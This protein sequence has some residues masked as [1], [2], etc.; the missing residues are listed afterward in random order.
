LIAGLL[1]PL[2]TK[3]SPPSIAV[4]DV[5][6]NTNILRPEQAIYLHNNL[7]D[8]IDRQRKNKETKVIISTAPTSAGK[9]FV[10]SNVT[11]A[12]LA[13]KN[14]DTRL[15]VVTSP[16]SGCVD[17]LHHG[18]YQT[19]HDKRLKTCNGSYV[20]FRVVNLA[21]FNKG[22]PFDSVEPVVVVLCIHVCKFNSLWTDYGDASIQIKSLVPPD[23]VIVDEIHYGMGTTSWETILADQGRNNKNF[24]PHWL[25]VLLELAKANFGNKP[26]C[27]VIGYTGT[28]TKSQSGATY[29]GRLVFDNSM[30]PMLKKK[31]NSTFVQGWKS[32]TLKH[33]YAHSKAWIKAELARLQNIINNIDQ[34]TWDEAETIGIT[35]IIPGGL[36]KFGRKDST[37]SIRFEEGFLDG[38]K[39]D[40]KQWVLSIGADYAAVTST[41]TKKEYAS[42]I[43][44]GI[45]SWIKVKTA[46]DI[47]KLANSITNMARAIFIAVVQSGNL[48]WD[49]A[50]LKWVVFLSLP[51]AKDVT[52]S[53]EQVMGRGNRFAFPGMYSHTI[54]STQLAA[55]NIPHEQKLALVEYVMFMNTVDI[56]YTVHPLL[57]AAYE[58]FAEDTHTPAEGKQIY[59]DAIKAHADRVAKQALP[60]PGF[61]M[62]YTA[63]GLNSPFTKDYCEACM[64]AGQFDPVTNKTF[65][66]INA[67]AS[68]EH[69]FGPVADI[70]WKIYW[71]AHLALDH[72]N[73]DRTDYRPENLITRDQMNNGLKTLFN[74]DYL[75]RYD[76]QGNLIKS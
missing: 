50:R 43:K 31:D 11:V 70:F 52:I 13:E 8:A 45:A 48:G 7:F 19:L 38:Y 14:P 30:P 51:T 71:E 37:N 3:V 64:N 15:V 34:S 33:T 63:G 32:L 24:K 18:L 46:F 9:S 47:I 65:C 53:I 74:K 72:K 73:G 60:K 58:K 12:A 28:P 1:N 76:A 10:I 61:T 17:R 5:A 44:P 67:R 22:A 16:D 23:F 6:V 4:G 49:I 42:S 57:Q 20:R 56:N 66:E 26:K 68:L 59:L 2:K 41:E 54:T 35:R 62:G 55:L 21:E 75:N 29:Q 36:F 40:F 25:P 69:E 39:E 27:V